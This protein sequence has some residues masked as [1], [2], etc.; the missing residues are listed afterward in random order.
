MNFLKRQEQR[1]EWMVKFD[2]D[3]RDTRV[4]RP[5]FANYTYA[6]IFISALSCARK[7]S[8]CGSF[9]YNGFAFMVTAGR[10]TPVAPEGARKRFGDLIKEYED[11]A[12]NAEPDGGEDCQE[13][14]SEISNFFKHQERRSKLLKGFRN[15]ASA[16]VSSLCDLL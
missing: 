3:H 2:K 12:D 14:V 1:V 15:L 11:S 8:F 10:C 4:H 16:R 13:V 7:Y 6:Y 5:L 9:M